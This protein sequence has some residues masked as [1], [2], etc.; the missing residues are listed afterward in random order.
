MVDGMMSAA[1]LFGS[2]TVN[3]LPVPP[4]YLK[5]QDEVVADVK[6]D[7]TVVFRDIS[8]LD[9]PAGLHIMVPEGGTWNSEQF[10]MFLS[11]RIPS[12]NRRDIDKI[13]LRAG[14]TTYNVFRLALQ[15]RAFNSKDLLWLSNEDET[16]LSVLPEIFK[17][18]FMLKHD[19][20]GNSNLNSPEGV[21]IKRYAVVNGD[22][23]VLKQR[24][25][26]SSTDVESEVAVYRL[27]NVLGV[28]CCPAQFVEDGSHLKSFSKFEYNFAEEFIVHVRS[29][30]SE[31]DLTGDLYQDLIKKFPQFRKNIEKMILLD[32]VTRQ[33]DRHLSNMALKVFG[34]TVTFYPLYDNGRSLFHEDSA[35]LS[36]AAVNNIELYSSEFGPIGTYF[37]V[38]GD[39]AKE[40]KPS[41]LI[42]LNIDLAEIKEIYSSSGLKGD[43]CRDAS[44]WTFRCLEHLKSLSK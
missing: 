8:K 26:T 32:F 2:I 25:H 24:L 29:A 9:V 5:W 14:M 3:P 12:A 36:S 19:L 22:Y 11:E 6:S 10:K 44:L 38:V 42:R 1:D 21:N 28:D 43:R 39:I 31:K 16:F 20:E 35:E 40:T 27:S 13:L 41:E 37:D 7:Y 18:V 30:V 17:S 4:K 15:T 23:G 33:T 34:D